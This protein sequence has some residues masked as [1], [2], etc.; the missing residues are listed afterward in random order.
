M[1]PFTTHR[2][3]LKGLRDRGLIINN[4]SKAMRILEAENYYNVINGYKDL[5]LQRDPQRNPIS[6]EKYNTGTKFQ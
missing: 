1:K 2:M 6:P 5:F 4:G 3:Q